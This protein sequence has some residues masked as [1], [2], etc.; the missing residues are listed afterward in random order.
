[1]R[2]TTKAFGLVAALAATATV[3]SAQ[4]QVQGSTSGAPALIPGSTPGAQIEYFGSQINT[5]ALG[6]PVAIATLGGD[7]AADMAGATNLNNYGS[8]RLT[9]TGT[10]SEFAQAFELTVNFT[11]PNV[12]T[13]TTSAT[14]NG[15]I[16][17]NGGNLFV[18]FLGFGDAAGGAANLAN[19]LQVEDT[20]IRYYVSDLQIGAPTV[21][22]VRNVSITG[23][24]AVVPEP[25]T[26]ALFGTGL[27]GLLSVA[28]RR[29]RATA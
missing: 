25:S 5:I 15:T 8:F 17:S 2:F 14:I 22:N 20:G 16:F 28:A 11:Q 3:S 26:Y 21:D 24:V 23:A 13:S 12:G 4:I 1:M 18:D 19:Y 7:A 10:P 9:T 6:S 29:R 27:A